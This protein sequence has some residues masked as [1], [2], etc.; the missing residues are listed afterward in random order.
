M[1][2]NKTASKSEKARS[3]A[4]DQILT[5]DVDRRS[6]LS[7]AVGA[8]GLGGALV[9]TG[10]GKGDGCDLGPSADPRV[11][12]GQDTDPPEV[13]RG[14]LHELSQSPSLAEEQGGDLVL[15]SR[16]DCSD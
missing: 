14:D 4:D 11:Q 2:Q 10:C 1:G 5:V 12:A 8:T 7:K 9:A 13:F 16:D 6:F 15:S 3:L